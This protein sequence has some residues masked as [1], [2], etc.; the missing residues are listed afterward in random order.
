FSG[1]G[2]MPVYEFVCE[3]CKKIFEVTMS[4]AEAG[5][6]KVVCPKCDSDKVRQRLSAF[7]AVTS[8]KS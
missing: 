4:M 2:K 1:G 3:A 5:V 6:K 7:S 8:R